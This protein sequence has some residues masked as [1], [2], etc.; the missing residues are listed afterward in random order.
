[1]VHSNRQGSLW[2]MAK[3]IRKIKSKPIRYFYLNKKHHKVLRISRSED[4]IVAWDY[5]SKKRVS[6]IWSVTKQNMQKAFT[7]KEVVKIF[8][9]D[10]WVIHDYIEEGKIKKPKQTYSIET[11]NPG[12]YLFSEDDLRD[13]HSYLLTVHIGRPRKD[14]QITNRNLMSRAELEAMMK[15]ETVL[16][17]K[18]NSGQYVPVWKQP[19]W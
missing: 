13:L 1:M 17:T 3:S 12:K 16:Y 19:D 7:V 10:R 15:E 8:S 14:G 2:P 6:Y 18:D 5:E 11:G 9:R 4:I